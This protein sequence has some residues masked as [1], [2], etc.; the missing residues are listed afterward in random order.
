LRFLENI[1]LH[2][3]SIELIADAEVS[4]DTDPY[5]REHCFQGDQIFPAVLGIEAMAQVASALEETGDVPQ[6]RNVNFNRPI[7]VSPGKSIVLRVAAVRRR[8]GVI[9][10]AVRSSA[11]SFHVDHFTAECVFNAESEC[12]TKPAAIETTAKKILP[13]NPE[14]DLYGRI[15]FHQG[16]FHRITAYHELIAK[17]CVASISGSGRQP[18]FARFLPGDM[19][20]GDAASRDAII[21]CVQACIPHKTVLPTGVDFIVTSAAWTSESVI[22]RAEEREHHGDD[23]IY[24]LKV[25]DSNG[26]ICERWNG[27]R[28]HAVAPIEMQQ[29]WPAALLVPY[30]E[31]RLADIL[32]SASLCVAFNEDAADQKS[33]CSCHRP[34]GKPEER[35]HIGMQLS[36][37]YCGKLVLTAHSQQP[38]GCDM[39]QLTDRGKTTWSGLLGEQWFSVA[40]MIASESHISVQ[41]AATQV[42]A[43]KESLRKCGAS[44]DQHLQIRTQTPDG[45]TILSSGNLQA[46]TFRTNIQ[47]F[48]D[49]VAFAFV[50]RQAP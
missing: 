3:P 33:A 13:L 29:P 1:R 31:R 14:G 30:L 43:L 47:G 36:R 40:Q 15:L 22:V 37:S 6:F 7:V 48:E 42:W 4:A 44:F 11:T 50:T 25:E 19:L 20:L 8:P 5:L 27:L 10:L 39:E 41:N 18:W 35:V 2:Y 12:N 16:R 34:D 9:A 24:D 21:H 26:R 38:V 49:Q 46:A 17:R 23:F 45:W 32:P 28:L